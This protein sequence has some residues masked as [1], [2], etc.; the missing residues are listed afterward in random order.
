MALLMGR[1]QGGEI[2]IRYYRETYLLKFE[3]EWGGGH[4]LNSG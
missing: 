2:T 3:P 4:W 1:E